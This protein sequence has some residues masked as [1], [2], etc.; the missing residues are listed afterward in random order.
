MDIAA[1]L[2]DLDGTLCENAGDEHAAY[3]AAFERAG[4]EPFGSPEELWSALSGS[5]APGDRTSYIAEGFRRLAAQYGRRAVPADDLA[6]ALDVES[7]FGAVRYREGARRALEAAESA[8]VVGVVTNGPARRQIPKMRTLDLRDRMATTVYAGDMRRRKPHPDPF[9][10]ALSDVDVPAREAL[11]VGNSLSYD[12]AGAHAAGMTAA[13]CPH[14]VDGGDDLDPGAY[15]PEHV[16]SNPD[17][18]ADILV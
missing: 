4:V 2:F 18:L 9:E 1:V 14:G 5:P 17:E 15:R 16:L 6:R 7:D 13:W 8:G 12:V 10:R 3:D 11:Y